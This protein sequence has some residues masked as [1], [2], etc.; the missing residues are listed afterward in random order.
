MLNEDLMRMLELSQQGLYCSQIL[1]QLGLEKQGK[2]NPDLID[3]M[4]GL[5]G[6]LGFSGEN[7]GALTGGACLLAL[8]VGRDET[9]KPDEPRLKEMIGELVDWFKAEQAQKYG[10]IN[11]RDILE[12]NPQNRKERCPQIVRET[13][14][15]AMEI[16]AKHGYATE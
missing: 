15:K 7:C 2:E 5:G 9:G 6:G 3:A 4:A 14:L 16:L 12:D 13:Y 1:L 11:C 10:G 8:Y